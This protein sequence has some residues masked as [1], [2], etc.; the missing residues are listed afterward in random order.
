VVGVV[1]ASSSSR[2]GRVLLSR[3]LPSKNASF[4]RSLLLLQLLRGVVVV[5]VE[6]F[7]DLWS[8][9]VKVLLETKLRI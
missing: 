5:V 1:S 8:G 4:S 3:F 6:T 7:H 9:K 2:K